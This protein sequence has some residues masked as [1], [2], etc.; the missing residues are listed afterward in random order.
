MA[1]ADAAD[2]QALEPFAPLREWRKRLGVE[3]S[4]PR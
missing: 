1:E 4:L 3:P 2:D